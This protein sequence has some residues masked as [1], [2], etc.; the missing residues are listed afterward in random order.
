LKG[1]EC[2][3]W[4]VA[5]T[6][7]NPNNKEF[8][9]KERNVGDMI[10]ELEWIFKNPTT[11]YELFPYSI[12]FGTVKNKVWILMNKYDY[13]LESLPTDLFKANWKKIMRNCILQFV[14]LHASYV[15]CDIKPANILVNTDGSSSICDFGWATPLHIALTQPPPKE[16]LEYFTKFCGAAEGENWGPKTDFMALGWAVKRTLVKHSL[17]LEPKIWHKYFAT[18]TPLKYNEPVPTKVYDDLSI[19]FANATASQTPS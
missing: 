17:P 9:V 12:T 16:Y 15:H 19:Y 11:F 2:K 4:I 10:Q 13:D 18:I 5:R 6:L 8:I 3:L 7:D 14:R 1:N